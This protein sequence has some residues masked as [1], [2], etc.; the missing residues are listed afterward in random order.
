MRPQLLLLDF[1]ETLGGSL[2]ILEAPGL[3]LTL[4]EFIQLSSRASGKLVSNGR[5]QEENGTTNPAV[6]GMMNQ[7]PTTQIRPTPA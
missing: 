5:K 4:K 3:D 2:G 6:S 7:I 1:N